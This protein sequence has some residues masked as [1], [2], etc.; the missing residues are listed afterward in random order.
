[1]EARRRWLMQAGALASSV[2][3][4]LWAPRV[5]AQSA[6]TLNALPRVAL[7]IG[8]SK[9]S[10]WPLRNP[11]NDARGIAGELQ[12]MGFQVNLKLD[13][14]RN[15][16]IEAIR[17][18][19]IELG[20]KKGIG[21]FY[22]A[23]HGAQL[24]WKNY[25][26]PVDAVIDRIE[27]MQTKTVELNS[28]LDG[29][30]KA[31]NPMN[32]IILDACRDNPFG[33]KAQAQQKGLSQF[34]APPGSLL[35]YATSPG[36]TAADGDGANGLYTEN[37]LRELKVPE[38]KIEDVFKRV[39][40]NVRRKSEGQQIP[41][42]STSLE[43]DFYFLPPAQV[44]K[45]S[46]EEAEKLFEEQLATWERIKSSKDPAPLEDFLR[47]Y[48]SGNFSELAQFRLDKLLAEREAQAAQAEREKQAAL[49]EKSR[50]AEEKRLSEEK[51]LAE[52]RQQAQEKRIAEERRV[53]EAKRIA[54]EKRLAAL[55]DERRRAEEA[56]LAQERKLAEDRRL[57]E[58]KKLADEIRLAEEKRLEY[59][60]EAARAKAEAAKPVSAQPASVEASPYTKGTARIDTN[61]KVGDRYEYR[62]TDIYTKIETRNIVMQISAI[63]DD[64]VI[65]G[66]GR[67]VTDFFGNPLKTPNGWKFT[68]AQ[69]YIAE[70]ALGKK[71]ITRFKVDHGGFTSENEYEFRVVTREKITVP[72]GT[73]DA[74]RIEGNGWSNGSR[75]G[76]VNVK[77]TYWI[78]PGIRRFIAG[79]MYKRHSSGKVIA[80]ERQEL[81]AYTQQ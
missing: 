73:F 79:E 57:A 76:S 15:E 18:F 77:P 60:R 21:M 24:A 52:E 26:I 7:I 53:A 13:A 49:A 10:E 61:F 62:E 67:L 36:N 25:L 70:Y 31:Q 71:W 68:G 75:G 45:V 6:S 65:F 58:E 59:E 37:L 51:K 1:M 9:Y 63:T 14:G 54:D 8:N 47:K 34:D 19:G 42:E 46:P 32:V 56:R 27:D 3:L 55:N 48:P 33:N 69:F 40:L 39:R 41:W 38:A 64:E 74:F 80:N 43:Q 72:A 20:R 23:G 28:L 4:P 22:Y 5:S 17:A 78:A 35:A 2:S 29:L 81:I 44:K 11:G 66:N 50:L 30:I 16:M 12:K